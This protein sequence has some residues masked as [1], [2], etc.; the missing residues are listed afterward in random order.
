MFYYLK[1]P[2]IICPFFAKFIHYEY[3]EPHYL[4]HIVST[5]FASDLPKG[6]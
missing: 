2:Y 5:I 4:L 1:T 3:I 6:F